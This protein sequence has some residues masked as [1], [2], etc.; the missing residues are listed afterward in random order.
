MATDHFTPTALAAYAAFMTGIVAGV[1]IAVL[2][3][4]L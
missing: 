3:A 4:L 2:R 1:G